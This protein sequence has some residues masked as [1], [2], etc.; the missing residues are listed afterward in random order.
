[1]KIGK[2]LALFIVLAIS[3]TNILSSFPVTSAA[4]GESFNLVSSDISESHLIEGVP[5]VGQ[6][7]PYCAY[8]SPTMVFQ[9]YGV[10]TSLREVLYNSGVGH[11]FKKT[12][13]TCIHLSFLKADREFLGE[14]YGLSWES[15]KADTKNMP[16]DGC[17]KEYWLR[18]KQ[19]ISQNI[20][21]LTVVNPF[22]LSSEKEFW[23]LSPLFSKLN[24][25]PPSSHMI[26]LV[27]YNETN[28]TVCYNDPA[29]L[30][31]GHPEKGV[32][33]W[34]NIK[35]FSEAVKKA[36]GTEY[37]VSIYRDIPA[38]PKDKT[39]IFRLAHERNIKRMLGNISAYDPSCSSYKLGIIGLKE[40]REDLKKIRTRLPTIF[41]L[42]LRGTLYRVL[43]TI[44]KI[45]PLFR[46]ILLG[47][48]EYY[49][50]VKSQLSEY[51]YNTSNLSNI[52]EKEA[53]LFEIEAENWSALD[54]LFL[55]FSKVR[56]F[57][58]LIPR[59]II[60]KMIQHLDNIISIEE[61]IVTL[62]D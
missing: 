16:A 38:E 2:L 13:P 15:W 39:E 50:T 22:L 24:I 43:S 21:V 58:V 59:I 47:D 3:L 42:K 52:C 7:G 35:E 12:F 4:D 48:Y 41:T 32:Y 60:S 34:Q 54:S 1:M 14:L 27:G 57:Q 19:N 62:R 28:G 51:L 8:A 5:Y 46:T 10:N 49:P 45:E 20:P 44:L 36:I 55:D 33:V 30:L 29:L 61:E 40:Y 18:I 9:Y 23:N 11:S 25:T 56:L 31:F 37:T 53:R 26:V 6:D 17:Q